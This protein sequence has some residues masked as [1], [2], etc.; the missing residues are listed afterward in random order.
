M[1]YYECPNIVFVF[2]AKS[3]K[4]IATSKGKPNGMGNDLVDLI[5]TKYLFSNLRGHEI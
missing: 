3:P 1:E 4:H 2:R 5:R